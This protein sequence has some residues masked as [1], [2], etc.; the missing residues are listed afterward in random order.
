MIAAIAASAP[1]EGGDSTT[2]QTSTRTRCG[3]PAGRQGDRPPHPVRGS[4]HKVDLA[5]ELL[6]LNTTAVPVAVRRIETFDPAH[7]ESVLATLSGQQLAAHMGSVT[8]ASGVRLGPM[9]SGLVILDV[10]LDRHASLPDH[11][12]HRLTVKAASSGSS[13]EP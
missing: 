9:Q 3:H 4:D 10:R 5:D 1:S 11:L 6:I 13:T 12:S 7:P 8:G 2:T